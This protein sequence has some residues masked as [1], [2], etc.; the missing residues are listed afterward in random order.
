MCANSLA[1]FGCCG[2]RELVLYDI[3]PDQ[4][5][6]RYINDVKGVATS[7]AVYL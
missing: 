5:R 6:K 7:R 4:I 2:T 1:M 3:C